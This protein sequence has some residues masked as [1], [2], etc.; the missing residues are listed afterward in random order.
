MAGR[1]E[2]L[3]EAKKEK[4]LKYNPYARTNPDLLR[5]KVFCLCTLCSEVLITDRNVLVNRGIASLHREIDVRKGLITKAELLAANGSKTSMSY[6]DFFQ[7]Y[8]AHCEGRVDAAG[9]ALDLPMHPV[10]EQ[11]DNPLDH[12]DCHGEP[13]THCLDSHDA[14]QSPG[15]D[16]A[17]CAYYGHGSLLLCTF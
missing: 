14:A 4:L 13:H 17:T 1:I 10:Q 16:G 3:V 5:D 2:D 12:Q 11:L 7:I 15:F 9:M 6:G 8:R